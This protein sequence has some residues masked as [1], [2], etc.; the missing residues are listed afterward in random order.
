MGFDSVGYIRGKDW[1]EKVLS[2]RNHVQ[3]LGAKTEIGVMGSRRPRLGDIVKM[4][5]R[6]ISV[7]AVQ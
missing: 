7:S 4:R 2:Y 3:N 6:K 5:S 1:D